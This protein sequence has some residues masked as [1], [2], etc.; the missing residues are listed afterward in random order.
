M[1]GDPDLY[2][3]TANIHPGPHNYSWKSIEY[4]SDFLDI[5]TSSIEGSVTK[6]LEDDDS[7]SADGFD[8]GMGCTGCVY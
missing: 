3:S 8:G 1:L 5:A 6:S 4:G 7:L 2:V